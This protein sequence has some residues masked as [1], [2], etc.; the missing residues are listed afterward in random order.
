MPDHARI[1]TRERLRFASIFIATCLGGCYLHEIG[2]AVFGWVQGISVL[3]TPAK[4]Y[5]LRAEV[6][7]NQRAWIS[8]GGVAA[9]VLLVL[10]VILWHSRTRGSDADAVLAGV[11][12]VPFAYTLRFSL[13]GRGHD[14]LEWQGAQS[15]LGANPAGHVVDLLFLCILSAGLFVWGFRK[16]RSMRPTLL[17]KAVGLAVAGVLLLVFLQVTNNALFDRFFQ[18]T[19]IVNV[20]SGIQPD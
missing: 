1:C 17:I 7:W 16:R 12:V 13:A 18:K 6:D 4:E 8:L 19:A 2:H 20:P 5:I 9:T 15:A 3:P 10:G 14:G 11:L